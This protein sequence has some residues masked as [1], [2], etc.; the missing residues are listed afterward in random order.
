MS[1]G[2]GRLE[3]DIGLVLPQAVGLKIGIIEFGPAE[4]QRSAVVQRQLFS[5]GLASMVLQSPRDFI[6]EHLLFDSVQQGRFAILRHGLR[7]DRRKADHC[8]QNQQSG[9][10]L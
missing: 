1:T 6:I 8:E 10:G 2:C 5:E 9:P 3:I 4:S 7:G